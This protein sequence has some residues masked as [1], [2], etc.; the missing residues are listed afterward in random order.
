MQGLETVYPEIRALGGETLL[1]GPE[2]EAHALEMM[3][4]GRATIP[5]LTDADGGVMELYRLAFDAPAAYQALS[6][7]FVEATLLRDEMMPGAQ[8]AFDAINEGYRQGKFGYLEV[9][10]AQRTLFE[11]RGQYL[12]ALA[13]YH[14]AVAEVERL[15]GEALESVATPVQGD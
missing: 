15:I 7:A 10:D 4:K 1:V 3:E 8:S 2:T 13:A 14:T 12:E 5:L 6:T 11:A 9:L